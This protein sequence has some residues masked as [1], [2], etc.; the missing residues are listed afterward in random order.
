MSSGCECVRQTLAS[1]GCV[2]RWMCCGDTTNGRGWR[3][4]AF[5]QHGDRGANRVNNGQVQSNRPRGL[6]A[7][8]QTPGRTASWG[9]VA[10]AMAALMLDG[11]VGCRPAGETQHDLAATCTDRGNQHPTS[12]RASHASACDITH[13]DA[14][15]VCAHASVAKAGND[16]G[17]CLLFA[18]MGRSVV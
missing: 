8:H 17:S 18:C 11:Y 4:P 12:S 16:G 9:W 3:M 6:S 13:H 7:S 10:K 15:C 5:H 14:A 2:V 1:L